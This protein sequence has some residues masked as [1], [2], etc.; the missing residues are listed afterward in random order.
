MNTPD[1]SIVTPSYNGLEYLRRAAASVRDQSGLSLEHI[2]VDACS[3]DGTTGWLEES[4][5]RAIVENDEGMYDAINKGMN[6]ALG[7]YFAYL[8]CDEQYL[9][10]TLAKV[11][12]AFDANPGV[13][14]IYGD[15]LITR[16]SGDL[17]SLRRAYS[18]RY[19][20]VAAWQLYIPTACLFY[21]RNVIDAGFRY[22]KRFKMSGDWE[23]ILKLLKAGHRALRIAEPLACF[24][25]TGKNLSNKGRTPS[26]RALE[27]EK[28]PWWARA[29]SYPIN[30][31][32]VIEKR[33]CGVHRKGAV[34]YECYNDIDLSRR[35]TFEV[36]NPSHAWPEWDEV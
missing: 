18:L 22:D 10:G 7:R 27:L 35:A 5:I 15:C 32:R 4:G 33:L 23:F 14:I 16:R 20:Y 13:D 26:E 9:P 34:R 30:A 29:F 11:R 25:I 12:D 28:T 19:A 24:A 3:T 21:R 36:A 2:V 31:A 6:V 8:N 1:F 17:L